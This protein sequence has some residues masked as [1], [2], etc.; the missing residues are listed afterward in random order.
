MP[1]A[2]DCHLTTKHVELPTF[3]GMDTVGWV[4]IC[5]AYFA[6]QGTPISLRLQLALI[7]IVGMTWQW[8]KVLKE[9]DPCL[10]WEKLKFT[11]F[12]FYGEHHSGN[13]FLQLQVLRQVGSI[14]GYVG[15]SEML[16]TQIPPI[17]Q[18]M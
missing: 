16:A 5:K 11:L 4:P 8:F 1:T 6:V 9:A 17:E 10:D 14:D 3:D 12:D 7:C 13:Q 2:D 18:Y 15:E